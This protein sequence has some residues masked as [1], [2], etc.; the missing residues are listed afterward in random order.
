[1]TPQETQVLIGALVGLFGALQAWLS[2]RSVDHGHQLNG[3]MAPRVAR[4]AA[5]VVVAD[6]AA[7]DAQPA[8]DVAAARAAHIAALQAELAALAP[9]LA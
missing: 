2:Y 4:I 8:V 5:A 1:M 7:T 9:G 6:K 3:L